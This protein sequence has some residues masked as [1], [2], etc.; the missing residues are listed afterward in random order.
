[1][2]DSFRQ[3]SLPAPHTTRPGGGRSERA[4]GQSE[5]ERGSR[6]AEEGRGAGFHYHET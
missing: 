5:G 4:P 3:I 2:K 1:L 6:R